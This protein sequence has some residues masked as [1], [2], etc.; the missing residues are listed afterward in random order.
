MDS[1][2][3]S[4]VTSGPAARFLPG[5]LVLRRYER[6]WLWPDA[7]AGLTVGAM[8]IP[9]SMGYAEL[10]DLPPQYGFYAGMAAL[11]VYAIV[12]TSRHL[13][14]GPEPGTA[15]LAAA[16]VAPVAAGDPVRYISL[17]AALALLVSAVCLLG[18]LARLGHLASM[19]S[20]PVLVGYISGVGL[21]LLSSQIATFTGVKITADSFFP[22]VGQ[23]LSRV[24]NVH[25]ATLGVAASA[26]LLMLV[27]RWRRPTFPAA[28]IAVVLATTVVALFGWDHHGVALVGAIPSGFPRPGFPD[29]GLRDLT[30]LL[31]AAAGIA[32]VG[33]T[34]NV[35]TA[36]AIATKKGYRIDPNQELFAL[37]AVNLA[38]GLSRGFPISSSASRT[39]VPASLGSRTQLVSVIGAGFVVVTLLS[40]RPALSHIPRAALAA[41]IV[42][43]AISIIDVP[44]FVSLWRFSRAECILSIVAT[45]GVIV[46]GVL[47]GIVIAVALSIAVALTRFAHPHDAVLG[48]LPGLDGWVDIDDFPNAVSADGLLVFRFDAPLFF[49]NIDRFCERVEEALRDNPGDE[50]WFVMDCEGIGDI[51][52]SAADG[53]RELVARLTEGHVRVVAVARAN[54]RVREQLRRASL[55]TPEGPI[56]HFPTINGAVRAFR[57]RI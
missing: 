31:P 47:P 14:V 11:L 55:L 25:G 45:F 44:A 6:S 20:R 16:A 7:V 32:L 4:Q 30:R 40:L 43:A 27:I 3:D 18:A 13:G 56:R 38:S 12:G 35:L 41:V 37:G 2:E 1:R 9:Q 19:L 23:F 10:A 39:A 22:R 52:A 49:L 21:T 5:L 17:M 57:E 46:F 51:D 26:L 34:D 36:R 24:G 53:L 54:D 50:E 28:L 8:L 42:T 29:V 33:F 48:D 15:I